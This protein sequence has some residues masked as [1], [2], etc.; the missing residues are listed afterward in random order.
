MSK[1]QAIPLRR[2]FD[3]LF[4]FYLFLVYFCWHPK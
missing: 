4:F 1:C 3:V 2:H